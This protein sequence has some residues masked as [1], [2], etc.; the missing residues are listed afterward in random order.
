MKSTELD[1]KIT[2]SSVLRQSIEL[3]ENDLMNVLNGAYIARRF[4]GKSRSW[5]SQR[6]N[7]ATVNGKPAEFSA[8]E[9]KILS[10]ALT[11]LGLEILD[12]A[13]QIE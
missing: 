8:D 3:K 5:F 7:H 10:Q 6:L 2:E 12:L 4:F 13:D 9:R 1:A 11:T